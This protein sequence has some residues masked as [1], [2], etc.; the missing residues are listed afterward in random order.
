MGISFDTRKGKDHFSPKDNHHL[1][2]GGAGKKV[3][4]HNL[5]Q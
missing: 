5:Q 3:G 2:E 4:K 1:Q